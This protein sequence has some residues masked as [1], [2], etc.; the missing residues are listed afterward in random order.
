[1]V[2]SLRPRCSKNDLALVMKESQSPLNGD[3]GGYRL[4]SFSYANTSSCAIRYLRTSSVNFA[5]A[6]GLPWMDRLFLFAFQTD[7]AS[8]DW[9]TSRTCIDSCKRVP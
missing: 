7:S 3:I 6:Y 5:T 9:R 8:A 2:A 4:A 1:M